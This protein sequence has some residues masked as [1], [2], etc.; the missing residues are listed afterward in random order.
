[1]TGIVYHYL[2]KNSKEF[3]K[4][5]YLLKT[6]FLKQVKYLK[7][8]NQIKCFN[9]I[10]KNKFFLTF[11]DGLKEHLWAARELKKLKLTAIF[12][13]NS[14][15]LIYNDFLK[16]HKTHLMLG[17]FNHK[18]LYNEL[19][20]ICRINEIP[21]NK[22][23]NKMKKYQLDKAKSKDEIESIKLK[24]L[25]NS[26]A[27]TNNNSIVDSLFNSLF[28]KKKQKSLFSKFYLNLKEI[29]MIK[30]MGMKI[31]AHSHSHLLMTSLNKKNLI[32]EIDICKKFFAKNNLKT[33]LFSYPYGFNGSYNFSTNNLLY[34][35][36]F[37]K[38]FVVNNPNQKISKNV[39]PRLNCNYFKYGQIK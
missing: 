34:K 26:S 14:Y 3:P 39:I 5:K 37:N 18:I 15:P 4:L 7:N 21:I 10:G 24:I 9:D 28:T 32:Q 2:K 27:F 31:G 36:K 20:S 33:N 1:M 22:N 25:L 23:Y 19:K 12:F 17:K 6:N 29:Y 13:I 30:N 11:D 16:V 38:L 35:K 8:K